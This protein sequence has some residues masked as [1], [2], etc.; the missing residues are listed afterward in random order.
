[1]FT[2]IAIER[3]DDHAEHGVPEGNIAPPIAAGQ[4]AAAH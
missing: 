2:I 4:A 3:H 1:M